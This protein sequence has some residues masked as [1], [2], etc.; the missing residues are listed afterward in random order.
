MPVEPV[1]QIP[2]AIKIHAYIQIHFSDDKGFFLPRLPADHETHPESP[3]DDL[4]KGVSGSAHFGPQFG[5]HI[6]IQR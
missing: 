3:I 2:S 4:F 5:R 1:D 6:F